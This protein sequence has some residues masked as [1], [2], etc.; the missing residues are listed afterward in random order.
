MYALTQVY[1]LVYGDIT[2]INKYLNSNILNYEIIF[3]SN[4]SYSHII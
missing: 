4:Y 1:I 3:S 2:R